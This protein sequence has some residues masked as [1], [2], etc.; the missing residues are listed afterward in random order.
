MEFHWEGRSRGAG[1]HSYDRL[2]LGFALGGP[3]TS[4]VGGDITTPL[5]LRGQVP[6]EKA[7]E[8]AEVPLES[9]SAV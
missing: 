9:L 5:T 3:L 2:G 8:D 7:T 6:K 1:L 4:W